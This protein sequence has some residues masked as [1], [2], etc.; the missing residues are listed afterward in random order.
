M[1]IIEVRNSNPNGDPDRE[2]DPRIRAHD[3]RGIISDVSFKRKLRELI[4]EKE[5]PVWSHMKTLM[6]LDDENFGIHVCHETREKLKSSKKNDQTKNLSTHHWDVRT[7]GS[8][9]LTE[10]AN[11]IRT[12]LV[13]FSIGFSVP[14]IQ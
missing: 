7:F 4:L 10:K 5:G 8:P 9:R 1:L 13:Q 6:S 12:C 2:S 14:N 11:F 3:G